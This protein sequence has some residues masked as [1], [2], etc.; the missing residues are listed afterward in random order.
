MSVK[1]TPADEKIEFFDNADNLD[2]KI[3]LDGSGNLK[4]ENFNGGSMVLGDPTADIYVGDGS[5]SVDIV[6]D[7]AG[8]LYSTANQHL[9]IGKSSLGGNDI[10]IDS[11]NWSVTDGGIFTFKEGNI[12]DTSDTSAVGLTLQNSEGSIYLYTNGDDLIFKNVDDNTFPFQMLNGAATNT[13]VMNS[14]GVEIGGNIISALGDI[15]TCVTFVFN[16]SDMD[17]GAVNLKAVS[18]DYASTQN[19]WGF[20]MPKSGKVKYLTLNTRNHT[21]TGTNEQTWKINNNNDNS[22]SGE[23]FQIAVARGATQDNTGVSGNATMELTQS[24]HSSTIWRGAVVVN[25]TF[26][27]LDEIRIQRTNANGVD[28]GDTTGVIYV[29]FD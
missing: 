8:R 13:L 22:T 21:V 16:R 19:H 12:I 6:Y 5:A 14:T 25:H 28:M 24:P 23:F 27:A 4:L 29:E 7:V 18:H 2:A 11:P 3:S 26:D 1:I 20:I 15:N 10:V 9:T 17:S